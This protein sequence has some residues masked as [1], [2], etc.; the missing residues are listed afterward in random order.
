MRCASVVSAYSLIVLS[1]RVADLSTRNMIGWSLGLTFWYDGGVGI[2][3]GSW[4]AAFAIIACTS[5]AAASMFRARS[6]WSVM[7]VL[8][9]AL[10]ELMDCSPAIVAN[11]FSSG[12]AIEA[13]TV[14]GLA[15]GSDAVT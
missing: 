11:C 10:V 12:N 15:P 3:G 8:P 2:C 13:A 14:S 6:N 1:G 7:L 9:W 5:W 4:R